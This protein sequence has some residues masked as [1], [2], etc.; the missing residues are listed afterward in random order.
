M[1]IEE[2]ISTSFEIAVFARNHRPY[3]ESSASRNKQEPNLFTTFRATTSWK[4]AHYANEVHGPIKAYFAPVGGEKKVEYEAIVHRIK[5]NPKRGETDTETLLGSSLDETKEEGLWEKY[6]KKVNT[7]Y[8][9]T[10]CKKIPSP[11]PITELIKVSD[12]KPISENYGYSYCLVYEHHPVSKIDTV[13]SPEEI[14]RPQDYYEG[15]TRKVAVDAYERS[16]RARAKCIEHYGYSC[17]VCGFNFQEKYGAIGKGF[18][19][20]HHLTPLS[21]IDELYKVNPLKDLRPIC[22]N[23]HAMIH[24][25]KPIFSIE[26]LKRKLSS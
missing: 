6:G 14:E 19:Y 12:E 11:F 7:L 8:V 18:I 22:P 16:A 10:H 24:S 15:A 1:T 3:L 2:K 26:E 25:R 9:I 23:C 17:A 5:L 21:E 4:S 13:F 20:V